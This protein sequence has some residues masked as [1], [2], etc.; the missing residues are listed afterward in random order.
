MLL[1]QTQKIP[2]PG[3]ILLPVGEIWYLELFLLMRQQTEDLCFWS[4]AYQT[5]GI[6]LYF[7]FSMYFS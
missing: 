7:T 6:S 1:L 5:K 2:P 4:S 3:Q